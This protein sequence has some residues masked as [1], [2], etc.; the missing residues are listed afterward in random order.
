[1]F[2][3]RTDSKTDTFFPKD[4]KMGIKKK[5]KK[6]KTP[7][8]NN[9]SSCKWRWQKRRSLNS[10]VGFLLGSYVRGAVPLSAGTPLAVYKHACDFTHR[11]M[12]GNWHLRATDLCLFTHKNKPF[13]LFP[14]TSRCFSITGAFTRTYPNKQHAP[15]RRC[16]GADQ[17]EGSPWHSPTCLEVKAAPSTQRVRHQLLQD[18]QKQSWRE[19]YCIS[20]PFTLGWEQFT[21]EKN[22][23]LKICKGCAAFSR[24]YNSKNKQTHH[25][26]R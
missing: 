22:T 16:I 7:L 20:R 4:R 6:K 12:K 10:K 14:T 11:K 19:S 3:E 24:N 23:H 1:L 18:N 5:K 15:A 21:T 13:F 2:P 8:W 26:G 9:F 17:P 25:A